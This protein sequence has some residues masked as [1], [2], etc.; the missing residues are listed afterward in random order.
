MLVQV[1]GTYSAL[2]LL[3]STVYKLTHLLTYLFCA[4]VNSTYVLTY[5]YCVK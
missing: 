4:L 5:T 3:D 2:G 1:T